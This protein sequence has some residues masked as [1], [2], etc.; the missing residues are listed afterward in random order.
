[1]KA[2]WTETWRGGKGSVEQLRGHTEVQTRAAFPD[3]GVSRNAA[4]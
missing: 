4:E 3:P 2:V 1:M